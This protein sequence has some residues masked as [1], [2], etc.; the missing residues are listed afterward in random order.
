MSSHVSIEFT[1]L[2]VISCL[3]VVV[4]V[5][6]GGIVVVT[7]QSATSHFCISEGLSN[8]SQ[9]VCSSPDWLTHL[10]NRLLSLSPQVAEH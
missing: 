7:G 10:T 2:V 9:P 3:R 5:V 6:V 1:L 4:C 8:W